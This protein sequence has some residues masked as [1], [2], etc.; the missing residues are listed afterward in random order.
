MNG[1][2]EILMMKMEKSE[3]KQNGMEAQ[4]CIEIL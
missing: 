1:G 3:N 4:K 2:G